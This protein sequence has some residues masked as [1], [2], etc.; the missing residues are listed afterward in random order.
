MENIESNQPITPDTRTLI[1]EAFV[2]HVL[3][4][5]REPVSV[6]KFAQS[7]GIREEEFYTYYTSFLGVKGGVWEQ[8][9]ERTI[10]HME[11]QPV[12][13]SYSARE[14]L[15]AFYFTWIEEMK[16]YRSYL[17]ALYLQPEGLRKA[18]PAELRGF[19]IKFQAF[20]NEII[21][22]G[23]A[24]DQIVERKYISDKY[25]DALWAETLFILQFWLKDTS[26]S[27]EKTDAAIEKSVNL[28]FDLVGRTAVDS[29][30]D[31]AK[32]LYQSK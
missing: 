13:A 28:A 30:V 5:G 11:A 32:F 27:F 22:Q 8:I 21:Q 12:H 31:F 3:E 20:A 1:T 4:T 26:T 15:L 24:T 16:K 19:K 14:K 29:L 18:M 9:F 10:A 2:Q 25:A 23:I 7:I 17:L 6:Y